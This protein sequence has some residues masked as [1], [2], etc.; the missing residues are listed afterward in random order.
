LALREAGGAVG[1]DFDR[2]DGA[3][4]EESAAQDASAGAGEEGEFAERV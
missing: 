2:A 3:P 4:A 1:V